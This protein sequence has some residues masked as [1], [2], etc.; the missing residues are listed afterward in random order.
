[1]R[2]PNPKAPIYMMQNWFG[3][4]WVNRL[5]VFLEMGLIM[6]PFVK[7]ARIFRDED[8]K[9]QPLLISFLEMGSLCK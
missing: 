9:G 5:T 6:S 4:Q 8:V 7:M 1:M 2:I 3:P